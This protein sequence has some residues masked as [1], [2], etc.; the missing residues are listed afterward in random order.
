M[1]I[2]VLP[3][4]THSVTV[5]PRPRSHSASSRHCVA[6][7]GAVDSVQDDEK[8]RHGWSDRYAS[9]DDFAEDGLRLDLVRRQREPL[10]QPAGRR[11]GHVKGRPADG[12]LDEPLALVDLIARLGEPDAQPDRRQAQV[13][14]YHGD[15]LSAVHGVHHF[16]GVIARPHERPGDHLREAE[17]PGQHREV[18]ELRRRHEPGDRNVLERRRQVLAQRQH[19][20]ADRPQVGEDVEQFFRGLAEAEHQAA[21]GDHL[22]CQPF[23]ALAAGRACGRN[24]PGRGPSGT[25]AAPFR[26]CG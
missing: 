25:A 13:G 16:V 1:P 23:D 9:G 20:A 17:R 8:R 4:S 12:H 22:R 24:R 19:V 3:G 21:L 14:R 6:L 5:R 11:G 7:A 18:V 10:G 26:C 2:A 15:S